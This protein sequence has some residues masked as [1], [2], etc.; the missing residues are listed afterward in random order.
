MAKSPAKK[1][2][3]RRPST[4]AKAA[5]FAAAPEPAGGV[6]HAPT[7]GTDIVPAAAVAA[8]PNFNFDLQVN[9]D[10][11]VAVGVV[12]AKNRLVPQ[13]EHE[14]SEVTRLGTEITK[15]GTELNAVFAA[16]P[17]DPEFEANC[18]A[19][20]AAGEKIG[21]RLTFTLNKQGFNQDQLAYNVA[22]QFHGPMNTSQSYVLDS[23]EASELR[24]EVELLRKQQ[25][26][27]AGAAAKTKRKLEP[28]WLKEQ[29]TAAITA[30]AMNKSQSGQDTVEALYNSID[31]AID[32]S[33]GLPKQLP[34]A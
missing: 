15:R 19:F 17:I 18:K 30:N 12:H 34:D 7:N 1:K 6:G 2:T 16:V 24:D 14:V 8:T 21:I 29:L 22:A 27:M 5:S 10:N 11:L 3:T 4:K 32:V 9:V 31:Q 28:G 13:L 26:T 23:D 33:S 25:A 20:V